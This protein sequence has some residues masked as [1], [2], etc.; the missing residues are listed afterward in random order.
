MA[1]KYLLLKIK[2]IVFL[3]NNPRKITKTDFKKLCADIKADPNFLKQRPPLINFK[4]DKYI[5]YAG[6]QR[7]SAA[8]ELGYTELYC[9]VEDNVSEKL[10]DERMLKDNLHR[11]TWDFEKLKTIDFGILSNSGF[12][13]K[14]L[15]FFFENKK[16]LVEDKYVAK[17]EFEKSYNPKTKTGDLFQ[18]GK[19]KLICGDSS[20]L[21][22]IERLLED[23]KIDCIYTDPPY[24]IGLSYDKGIKGNSTHKTYTDNSF[25]DN[26]KKHDYQAWLSQVLINGLGF[27]NGSAHVFV[28]CDPKYIGA[29]QSVYEAI[30]V[31]NK[32]VCF[33]VKNHLNPVV[34]MAFNRLTEP[35][36][37][38]T[39][40]KP[41]LNEHYQKYTEILNNGVDGKDLFKK[42]EDMMDIWIVPR[43][44][45][46]NYVHPTQKPILLH[47]KPLTRCT[48][49]GDNV[50]DFFGGS[51][52]T[53]IA[54]E[55]MGRNSF[56]IEKDPVF[57]D[58]IISRWEAFTNKKA[59]NL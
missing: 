54:C 12:E 27:I 9:W 57:C 55:Q 8:I 26:L 51:G 13:I 16:Q 44:H 47:E 43:D 10:Q 7:V 40:G 41:F 45:T 23:T 32:S 56:L 15:G 52:S 42:L 24:N 36:V 18:L 34:Q 2:D 1:P 19:H 31:S 14:D 35:V 30:G 53:M 38:G 46:N 59:V 4:D 50:L 21:N 22:T 29:I 11:G 39:V 49:P 37:Y 20:D 28:W 48:K 58:V 33:W 5:C 6:Y 3:E 17:E 25:N